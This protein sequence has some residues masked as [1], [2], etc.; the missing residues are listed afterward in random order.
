MFARRSGDDPV[1]GI[2]KSVLGFRQFLLRGLSDRGLIVRRQRVDAGFLKQPPCN[3]HCL[4]AEVVKFGNP[5]RRAVIG[6]QPMTSLPDEHGVYEPDAT[7]E[8]APCGRSYAAINLYQCDDNQCRYALEFHSSYRGFSGPIRATRRGFPPAPKRSTPALSN[9]CCV[10]GRA[11]RRACIRFADLRPP[12]YSAA[13]AGTRRG[14]QRS[15]PPDREGD[16][17][18]LSA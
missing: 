14:R 9:C 6:F 18:H 8:L 2:I 13:G 12:V 11:N 5:G 4:P 7:E 10:S 1:L 17:G 3:A 15:C 16:G